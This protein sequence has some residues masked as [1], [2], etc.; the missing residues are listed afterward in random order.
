MPS[1]IYNNKGEIERRYTCLLFHVVRCAAAPVT[2]SM[3]ALLD[4]AD[5]QA[6]EQRTAGCPPPSTA[7]LLQPLTSHFEAVFGAAEGRL[8]PRV[9]RRLAREVWNRVAGQL[10][11][12]LTGDLEG[13]GEGPPGPSQERRREGS[14]YNSVDNLLPRI[15]YAFGVLCELMVILGCRLNML[16]LSLHAGLPIVHCSF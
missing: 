1:L 7:F 9:L 13:V 5:A 3:Q 10:H 12:A 16:V 2:T 6:H 14:I 15:R 11:D 8:D 4:A